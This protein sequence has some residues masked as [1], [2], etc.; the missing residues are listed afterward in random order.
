MPMLSLWVQLWRQQGSAVSVHDWLVHGDL[1]TFRVGFSSS[2]E[3]TMQD[4][5]AED[6]DLDGKY[7]EA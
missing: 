3:L 1:F 5:P 6:A 2:V 7:H 4:P